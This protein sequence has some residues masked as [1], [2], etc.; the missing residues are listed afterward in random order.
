MARGKRTDS[1]RHESRSGGLCPTVDVSIPLQKSVLP[2][3]YADDLKEHL[4]QILNRYAALY[5]SLK[6]EP[7]MKDVE[8]TLRHIMRGH[9]VDHDN[10]DET[11]RSLLK[12]HGTASAALKA[13]PS[14]TGP[15]KV[16]ELHLL[17]ITDLAALYKEYVG[18]LPKHE[19]SQFISFV[20]SCFIA[21]HYKAPE[22][23]H[24]NKLIIQALSN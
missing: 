13:M 24:L 9:D 6:Y 19:N 5:D 22:A 10:M 23:S 1:T 17:F 21:I 2:N 16:K 8:V 20:E 7:P 4:E 18:H 11:S 15:R 14:K 12:Q 3:G